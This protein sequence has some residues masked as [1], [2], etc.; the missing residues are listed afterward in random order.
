MCRYAEH[1]SPFTLVCADCDAGCDVASF[2]Q[3]LADGWSR[4]EFAPD[5]PMA[6]YVGLCPACREERLATWGKVVGE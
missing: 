3:A 1:G 4:I 5:L 6:N 2:D